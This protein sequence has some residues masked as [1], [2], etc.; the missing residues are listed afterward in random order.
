MYSYITVL[1]WLKQYIEL[2][3][4]VQLYYGI[5]LVETVY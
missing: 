2:V 4:T 3:F 1:N 5:K